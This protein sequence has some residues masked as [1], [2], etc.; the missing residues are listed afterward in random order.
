MSDFLTVK[1]ATTRSAE[2]LKARDIPSP[3]LDAELLMAHVL[4]CE[5]IQL[6]MDP[7]RPLTEAEKTEYRELIRRRG[8]HEP[9][10]YI[11]GSAGFWDIDVKVD[12]RAL[13]PRPETERIIELVLEAAGNDR[14]HAL[15]IVDVGCGSG[16]LAITLAKEFP[17]AQVVA[18]DI[19][20]DALSLTK[21]NAELNGVQ[22]RVHTVRGDLLEPLIQKGSKADI[23][24]SNPPYIAHHERDIMSK[25][26][27]AYEPALALFAD[28]DGFAIIDRL[29]AQVPLTLATG[30]I[31]AMEFGSPQ[32]GGI[33]ERAQ[34]KFRSWRVIQ[35]WNGHDRVLVIDAPGERIWAS[36]RKENGESK[37]VVFESS[38]EDFAPEGLEEIA[39]AALPEHAFK[40]H[41]KYGGADG[42]ELLPEIDL[43][44]DLDED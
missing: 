33:R 14:S 35:D 22:D 26:V 20:P 4:Q 37:P 2:W 5:R 31:F 34:K 18:L 3:R 8:E 23:I 17:N 38:P 6:F 15:R 12:A 40:L 27:E 41:A 39:E 7:T 30:G 9:V 24:V 21:E 10:A 11:V 43:R 28:N 44:G 32:G 13:I 16:V 1:E 42:R 36:P 29:L 25:G 19:S